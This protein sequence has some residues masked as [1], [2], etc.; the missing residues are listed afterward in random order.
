M[1]ER[2]AVLLFASTAFLAGTYLAWNRPVVFPDGSAATAQ[3]TV[4][5][6]STVLSAEPRSRGDVAAASPHES[7]PISVLPVSS[8]SQRSNFSPNI[9]VCLTPRNVRSVKLAIDGPFEVRPIGSGRTLAEGPRWLEQEVTVTETG[10]QFEAQE[11]PVTRLEIVPRNSPSVWVDGR[12]YRG[13]LRLFRRPGERFLVVNVLPLE[14]YLASVVDSEMPLTFGDAAR[15]AQAVV[16][17]TYALYQ[18]N[19]ASDHTYFDVYNDSRSQKYLGYQYTSSSGRRL[20]GETDSSRAAVADTAGIVCMDQKGLMCTYYSAVCGGSTTLGSEFFSD[21]SPLLQPV[22]CRWCQ[23]SP[24]FRWSETVTQEKLS[25]DLQRIFRD[26]G[27]FVRRDAKLL[28]IQPTAAGRVPRF[29]ITDGVTR[30]AISGSELRTSLAS[31]KLP[32]PYVSV[33]YLG[34]D[35]TFDG[36]GHGH[37]VGLC[38]WGARG[39]GLSGRNFRQILQFYYPGVQLVVLE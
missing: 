3:Q 31:V 25:E 26:K 10:F 15:R 32:S 17:R 24:L 7:H 35:A 6:T 13:H 34:T 37:G 33:R 28:P 4:E 18:M 2:L 11:F 21:A 12:M 22:A 9:R 29:E 16:A 23:P 1:M 8:R 14:E 19:W 39:L 20:A 36:K 5:V 30:V 38:Q 27:V